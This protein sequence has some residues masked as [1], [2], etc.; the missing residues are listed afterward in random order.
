MAEE[1]PCCE[2]LLLTD[3]VRNFSVI[4]DGDP[5]A[6]QMVECSSKAAY[7]CGPNGDAIVRGLTLFVLVGGDDDDPY[8]TPELRLRATDEVFDR[9]ESQFDVEKMKRCGSETRLSSRIYAVDGDV[10]VLHISFTPSFMADVVWYYLVYDSSAASLSLLSRLPRCCRPVCTDFPLKVK[11]KVKVKAG[12]EDKKL[13]SLV[14]M[15]ERSTS[16][17][18]KCT[19]PV[20]CLWS[21]P[22]PPD[23]DARQDYNRRAWELKARVRVNAMADTF[24][25]HTVFSCNRH[26]V[27]GDLAQGILYCG[28]GDL[29]DDATE[30]VVFKHA[31]LP[32]ECRI[33]LRHRRGPDARVPDHEPRRGRLHL[34]RPHRT[35]VRPPRRYEGE[36]VDSRRPPIGGVEHAEGV[37]DARLVRAGGVQGVGVA[38]D[39]ATRVPVLEAA[40]EG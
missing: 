34:V 37:Q 1:E 2:F 16:P 14:L 31:M 17:S 25:A 24:E 12:E 10:I 38:G 35:V 7:G 33:R 21:P 5:R 3:F 39:R 13:Y 18:A 8:M 4:D 20:L 30:P 6:Y 23:N 29:T 19:D 32:E 26:A 40:A 9:V 27:W 28:L 15:A 22:P 11:V 36:G